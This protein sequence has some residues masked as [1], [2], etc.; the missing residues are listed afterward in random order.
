MW[1]AR[2]SILLYLAPSLFQLLHVPVGLQAITVPVGLLCLLPILFLKVQQ[3][4]FK[5]GLREDTMDPHRELASL[6]G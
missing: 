1:P 6:V 2:S 4:H 5:E 3:G